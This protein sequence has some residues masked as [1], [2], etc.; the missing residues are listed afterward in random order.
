MSPELRSTLWLGGAF[1]S[2]LCA[3]AILYALSPWQPA[4]D[5]AFHIQDGLRWTHEGRLDTDGLFLRVPF[6]PV[7]LGTTFSALGV[8]TGLMVLQA[9]VVLAS[10]ACFGLY[11][12]AWKRGRIP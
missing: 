6:W 9:G 5:D 10:I 1:A 3:L 8:R 2:Y 11:T 12:G 7:L 4:F